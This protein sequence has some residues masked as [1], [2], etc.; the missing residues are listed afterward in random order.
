MTAEEAE[1]VLNIRRGAGRREIDMAYLL[2]R[3]HCLR[4]SQY[5]TCPKGRDQAHQALILAQDAYRT[6]TGESTPRQ[7]PSKESAKPE[8]GEDIPRA[9]LSGKFTPTAAT[10]SRGWMKIEWLGWFSKFRFPRNPET[11]VAS[12]ISVAMFLIALLVLA[13]VHR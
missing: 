9:S 7:M 13:C 2:N 10:P 1:M 6:L 4:R 12:L 5:D 11:I 8:P 3:N